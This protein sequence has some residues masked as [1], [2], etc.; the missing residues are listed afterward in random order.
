M[1][2]SSHKRFHKTLGFRLTFW[3][4]SIFIISSLTL[5]IVSFA[6]VFSTMRDNR[7][8]IQL[9]LAQYRSIADAG[10][11]Q[12]IENIINQQGRPSQRRSFF[13][14]VIGPGDETLFLSNPRLWQEFDF[15][16]VDWQTEGEWQYFTSNRDATL[17]EVTSAR[18]ANNQLLQVGKRI[19]DREEILENFRDTLFATMIP[20]ILIGLGG[21]A[22]VAFRALR[23]I[24]ALIHAM[25]SI[26]ETGRMDLR[27]PESN[28][29]DEMDE[30]VRLFNSM[31]ERVQ[32]LIKG[33]K[34]ALDNV[35]HDLR[36][37]MT[38]LR[39]TAEMCLE[40]PA[41]AEQYKESLATCVEE[42]DRILTLLNSIM[43]VSEAETGTMRLKLETV[44]LTKLIREMVELYQY[45]AEDREIVVSMDCSEDI[46]LAA[47][48]IR[49]RQVIA[50]LLDNAI[51]YNRTGGRIVIGARVEGDQAVITF[52]DTGIGI[53]AQELPEI[54][55]RLYRGDKS[56][57][58]PGL[59]LGLSVVKAIVR[60]HKGDVEVSSEPG[61]GSDFTIR[62]PAG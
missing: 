14:R 23:P 16:R 30:L 11:V 4:S 52:R 24:R 61:V 28:H 39:G 62:L 36:T 17:L 9:Q 55:N 29:Q 44:N 3:Y 18:L 21:G 41:K 42:S 53:P 47:D 56:R 10:G 1:P 59:G 57:S 27:V 40:A 58:E 12:A 33:M 38:R 45:V 5:S 6:F 60:A 50:N 15:S 31:L 43:D 25:R 46:H 7:K 19:Q 49:M 37:P 2:S 35:A 54:W 48:F 51:K 8:T 20:M 32:R 34:D 22:F 13:V 26:V